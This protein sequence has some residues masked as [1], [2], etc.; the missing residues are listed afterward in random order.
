MG[1]ATLRLRV[2]CT[3]TARPPISPQKGVAVRGA[4]S[5]TTGLTTMPKLLLALISAGVAVLIV[6]F[7]IAAFWL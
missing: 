1:H 6:A 3:A 2:A 5:R 7:V 4:L